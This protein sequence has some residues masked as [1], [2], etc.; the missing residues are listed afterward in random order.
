MLPLYIFILLLKAFILY[1]FC[2]THR[3]IIKAL[4]NK[5]SYRF[6]ASMQTSF[7]APAHYYRHALFF[8][9]KKQPAKHIQFN[10]NTS[11]A[12]FDG[13]SS[14]LPDR[15]GYLRRLETPLPGLGV[16]RDI[17]TINKLINKLIAWVLATIL[18]I[19]LTPFAL[20]SLQKKGTISIIAIEYLEWVALMEFLK[21]NQCKYLYHFCA[22]EKDA[23]FIGWLNKKMGITNH[24]VP[25]S[26]P[27]KNFYKYT[28]CDK[29]AITTPFQKP[30]IDLLSHNWKVNE[31]VYW[32]IEYFQKLLPYLNNKTDS[33]NK[34]YQLA[35]LSSGIWLRQKQ[36]HSPLGTGDQ[37]SELSL[38][39][40]LK[41]FLEKHQGISFIVLLHP[42]EKRSEEIY[43][44]AC[45]HYR[46]YFGNN[47]FIG[48][49]N[50]RSFEYFQEVDTSIAAYSSTNLQRLFCG[51][52]TLYAPLEFK[53]KIY[54]GSAI[55]NIAPI[56]KHNLFK[57]LDKTLKISEEE[58][59]NHFNLQEYH[60]TA[61]SFKTE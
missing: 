27:L 13:K 41:E 37:E 34:K 56:T 38:M 53:F 61:Y 55:E 50:K 30:E 48:E 8:L 60:Y 22:Y 43:Q 2:K 46:N 24:K 19:L 44:E 14:A 58:F 23:P 51:Y 39:E 16:S 25:S 10:S 6:P 15:F 28:Y 29:L 21:D 49:R 5:H 52:K 47:I 42:I 35:F 31:Y 32:P 54:E 1:P 4:L 26:N 17:L 40:Y 33:Q 59:F 57:M 9:F 11:I 36:G 45:N 3:I 20:V 7:K 12:I 18:S